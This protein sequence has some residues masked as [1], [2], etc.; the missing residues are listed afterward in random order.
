MGTVQIFQHLPA[1]I[2]VAT[3]LLPWAVV[4]MMN[5]IG[6][7]QRSG[8]DDNFRAHADA[9][10]RWADHTPDPVTPI[11]SEVRPYRARASAL[12]RN[13]ESALI[14]EEAA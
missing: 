10:M 12:A 3:V 9:A 2:V 14:V 11:T 5:V 8:L 4:A 1:A 6:P 7:M 13:S